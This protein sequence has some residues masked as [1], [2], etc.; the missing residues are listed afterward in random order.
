[1]GITRFRRAVVVILVGCTALAPTLTACGGGG[2]GA[3]EVPATTPPVAAGSLIPSAFLTLDPAYTTAML[4]TLDYHQLAVFPDVEWSDPG[5]AT[6]VVAGTLPDPPKGL[7]FAFLE[8]SPRTT[9]LIR[10]A[11]GERQS[12]LSFQAPTGIAGS[13][14]PG[15]ALVGEYTQGA[16]C[17]YLIDL[18]TSESAAASD[19]VWR[20]VGPP[21]VPIAVRLDGNRPVEILFGMADEPT[22]ASL[23]STLPFGLQ[24]LWLET[25]VTTS[26]VAPEILFLGISPD[27]AWYAVSDPSTTP[28]QLEIRRYD[29]S[30]SVVFPPQSGSRALG[31]AVFSP[32]ARFVAW[33]VSVPSEEDPLGT[34]IS[35]A[36]TSGGVPLSLAADQLAFEDQTRV[37]H[38]VPVAWLDEQ[39]LLLQVEVEGT[40]QV[41][42]IRS[43]GSGLQ[44]AG[45]GVFVSLVYR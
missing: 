17:L 41:A 5:P 39:T 45:R 43:D 13:V 40:P 25:G 4:W 27:L 18:R 35:I 36:S 7:V 21:A 30:A 12:V 23:G 8:R 20:Q 38:A 44:M 6:A 32:E 15:F 33:S 3:T 28:P 26:R 22:S 1:M 42:R 37:Q 19:R 10:L 2:R 9:S 29:G 16:A 11:G 14:P 24:S 34:M 31:R